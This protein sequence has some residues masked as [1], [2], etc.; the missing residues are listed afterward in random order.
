MRRLF[1]TFLILF[2]A[3]QAFA[4]VDSLKLAAL[5]SKLDEYVEAIHAQPLEEQNVEVDYII[6]SCEDPAL[7]EH[8]AN[9]LYRRFHDSKVMGSENVAV[10]IFDTW[11]AKGGMKMASDTDYLTAQ[12]FA[13][14]NRMSLIGEHAPSLDMYDREGN[15][16]VMEPGANGRG[17]VV[18][19]FDTDCPKCSVEST[20]LRPILEKD[21]YPVD[22]YLICTTNDREKWEKYTFRLP[23]LRR[24]RVFE[25]H[26]DDL[27]FDYQMK[28]GVIKTPLLF[29]VDEEGTIIGRNLNAGALDRML[30]DRYIAPELEYGNDESMAFYDTVFSSYDE[31]SADDFMTVA[32][33]IEARTLGERNDTTMYRQMMGDLLYYVTNRRD[34]GIKNAI[35][36][37]TDSKIISRKDIWRSDDDALK[38]V[39]L[40]EFLQGLALKTAIGERIPD[41]SLSGE[42]RSRWHKDGRTCTRR[43]RNLRAQ[44][45]I[46]LFYVDGCKDCAAEKAAIDGYL[47]KNKKTRIFLVNMES[48]IDANPDLIESFDLS[49]SP[50]LI[51]YDYRGIVTRKYFTIANR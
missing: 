41:V 23:E 35:L 29:L 47:A 3:M 38:V 34:E 25:I 46:L 33:H 43:I 48:A 4:Q 36:G 17:S 18:Y 27:T 2:S 7:R 22:V 37:F 31:L 30:S 5:G 11:F 44:E 16:V 14:F 40:A 21:A 49:A 15:R 9:D 39:S 45:N 26:D 24:T 32:D 20:L 42:L 1:A 6:S 12:I 28:Y 10:H 13:E 51:S 19:F 8:V 50:F